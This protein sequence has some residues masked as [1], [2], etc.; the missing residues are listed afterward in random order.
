MELSMGERKAV[1]DKMAAA[2]RRGTRAEK[3][4][5]LDQLGEL[6]GWHRDYARAR[7]R[8]AGEIRV[9]RVR[10]ARTP[11]YSARVVSALELCWRAARQP[12]GKRLAPMLAVL[13]PL[14]RR[15]GELD[16]DDDEARLLCAMSAATIDRRL[17]GAK[18]L[19]ELRGRSH[20]KPGTLLKSQIPIRTWSEWDEGV[21][22]FCEIDLVGHEGGNSFGEFCFTLTV[23]DV[24]TGWTVNRSVPN[25]AALWVT[26]AIDQAARSMPFRVLGH[27]SDNGSEF[28][29]AHL[30]EYCSERKITFTRSRPGNKNDGAHVEQKNWTHVRE[31]VG[32]LRF[33]TPAELALLNR[34][35][36]LDHGFTNLL[37]TQQKLLSRTRVGAKVIKRHDRATT[38]YQRTIDAG[39]LSPAR[40]GSL[41]RQ[42]NALHP[43]QLQREIARLCRQLER[44]ALEKAP[45][46]RRPVNRAFNASS[47][48]ELLCEATNQRS[49]RI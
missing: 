18:V 44:L 15:D 9:A 30:F 41:T 29:N 38:P 26:E 34:I 10:K 36:A 40:R 45:A 22:G 37:L 48:P 2:Y 46:P 32:Y 47:H 1:T 35:W 25:K 7:L 6:T 12:A 27:D 39:V 23:T 4:A 43:G 8:G 14:L 13:V 5:V 28:I 19:A 3:S 21:P 17:A 49:R 31:L 42:R 11:V 33:D 16:L 24:A 20:T